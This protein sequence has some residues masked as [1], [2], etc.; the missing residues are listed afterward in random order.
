MYVDGSG[1]LRWSFDP[2][3]TVLFCSAVPKEIA[4]GFGKTQAMAMELLSSYRASRQAGKARAGL[5]NPLPKQLQGGVIIDAREAP[6]KALASIKAIRDAGVAP[7]WL[8]GLTC[9]GEMDLPTL[10][11][12]EWKE[13]LAFSSARALPVAE[14]SRKNAKELVRRILSLSFS[15]NGHA[16]LPIGK[17]GGDE[18]APSSALD[19]R[20]LLDLAMFSPLFVVDSGV[21]LA[22]SALLHAFARAAAV[23][24]ALMPYRDFCSEWWVREGI[25]AFCHP[26][27]YYPDE[28]E[29]WKLD[30]QYMYGPDV[31][32]APVSPGAKESRRLYLPDGTWVHLWTSRHYSKG[33]FV[34]DAPAG[35][36]AVFYR[37]DSSF[38]GLFDTVRQMATRL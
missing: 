6:Q 5:R 8:A 4:M 12:D 16:F 34:I 22:G 23:Y 20:R 10:S 17:P 33:A 1:I 27:L 30:D 28:H 18:A 29:L 36:P 11:A 9:E 21:E 31:M 24:G 25:P 2:S 37:E 15:G 35:R 26:A 3:R 19:I 32:I 7:A 14:L 13:I 38:A